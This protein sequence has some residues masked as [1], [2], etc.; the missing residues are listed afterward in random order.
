MEAKIK[1]QDLRI[2]NLF[3]PNQ[4][5]QLEPWMFLPESTV[6]FE[7]I[8]LTEVWLL[9]FSFRY[10]TSHD[11]MKGNLFLTDFGGKYYRGFLDGS[12]RITK[13]L[14]YVHQLQNLFFALTGEELTLTETPCQKKE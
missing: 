2:G 9:K 7:P 3:N 8:E 12:V 14:K 13:E 5:V 1:P 11:F 6:V 10:A 4:P